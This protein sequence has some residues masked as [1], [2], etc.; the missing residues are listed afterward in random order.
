VNESDTPALLVDLDA[1]ERN[2]SRLQHHLDEQGIACRP[3]VET[4][5]LP[6]KL[7]DEVAVTRGGE[8]VAVWPIAARGRSR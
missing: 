8:P 4:H 7:Y 1:V 3:H 5:R 2:I 6:L